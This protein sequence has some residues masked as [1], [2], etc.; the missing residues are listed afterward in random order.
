MVEEKKNDGIFKVATFLGKTLAGEGDSKNGH[1]KRFK[2][3]LNVDGRDRNMTIFSGDKP[4]KSLPL[5]DLEEGCN[6]R[7]GYNE[8]DRIHTQ[9]GE[10]YKSRTV[11]YIQIASPEDIKKYEAIEQQ[12]IRADVPQVEVNEIPLDIPS[13][14]NAYAEMMEG[15][16]PNLN[17]FIGLYWRKANSDGIAFQNK[18]L[19][20]VMLSYNEAFVKKEVKEEAVIKDEVKE[21]ENF[22][23]EK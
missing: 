16:E 6:Y 21:D 3:V 14:T 10:T 18:L 4:S 1:W 19:A 17:Q 2:L 22:G 5:K 12:T 15:K 13:Y 7:I 23:D 9:T 11:F 20:K 8:E